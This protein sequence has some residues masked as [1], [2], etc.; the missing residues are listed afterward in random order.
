MEERANWTREDTFTAE[1]MEGLRCLHMTNR[2]M[3]VMEDEAGK[4]M[5][6]RDIMQE[7]NKGITVGYIG[8]QKNTAEWRA[9]TL[10]QRIGQIG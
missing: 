2:D 8:N 4:D 6:E 1:Y 9:M 5:S 3:E 10:E 7:P